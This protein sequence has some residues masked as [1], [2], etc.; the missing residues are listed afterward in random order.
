MRVIS[1]STDHAGGER[2]LPIEP[3][4]SGAIAGTSGIGA[5]SSLPDA[6]AKV[7]SRSDLPTFVKSIAG[8][9]FV[10]FTTYALASR[11]IASW[12]E[13]GDEGDQGFR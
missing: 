13:A 10:E 4:G 6:T 2:Q 5:S 9:R 8:R 7:P 12:M 11:L 1:I 3:P